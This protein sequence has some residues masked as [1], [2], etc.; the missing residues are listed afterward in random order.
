[1]DKDMINCKQSIVV[2]DTISKMVAIVTRHGIFGYNLRWLL[3][4]VSD[5]TK[6]LTEHG[7]RVDLALTKLGGNR[8][9]KAKVHVSSKK[10]SK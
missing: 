8:K 2:L 10:C 1:M 7:G 3:S 6:M 9:P 5:N 4:I